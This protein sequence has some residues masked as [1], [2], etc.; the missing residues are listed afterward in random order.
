MPHVII[1]GPVDLEA[2]HRSISPALERMPDGLRRLKNAYLDPRG[3]TLLLETLVMEG[4]VGRNFLV[5][6]DRKPAHRHSVRLDPMVSVDRTRGV[7]AAVAWVARL[8]LERCPKTALHA[9]NI[10]ELEGN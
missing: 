1:E 5:R 9:T 2:L 4:G 7:I 3:T 6:V 10:Q 8:I